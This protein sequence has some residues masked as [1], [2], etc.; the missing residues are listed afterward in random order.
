MQRT[1]VSADWMGFGV[2][3]IIPPPHKG[4]QFSQNVSA[5]CQRRCALY[6]RRHHATGYTPRPRRLRLFF[7]FNLWMCVAFFLLAEVNS[8]G[9]THDRPVVLQSMSFIV[10]RALHSRVLC[11]GWCLCILT[12]EQQHKSVSTATAAHYNPA[13]V[14]HKMWLKNVI[15]RGMQGSKTEKCFI[16][17]LARR[18]KVYHGERHTLGL[19][20]ALE[21]FAMGLVA[22]VLWNETLWKA[23]SG[24][25]ND[26][27]G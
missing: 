24:K 25:H 21:A 20:A 12:C 6:I 15:I 10:Q 3:W 19:Q 16:G 18:K 17:G 4:I 5:G 26:S 2:N 1:N 13:V 27:M 22:V 23:H 11:D 14:M 7:S 8:W 9:T